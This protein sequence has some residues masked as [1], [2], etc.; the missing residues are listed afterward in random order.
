MTE[1]A[2]SLIRN[3]SGKPYVFSL[4]WVPPIIT[5]LFLVITSALTLSV[6][7]S[8]LLFVTLALSCAISSIF[9]YVYLR[10]CNFGFSTAVTFSLI[11][12]LGLF[13]FWGSLILLFMALTAFTD[14]VK[15]VT[16]KEWGDQYKTLLYSFSAIFVL[17]L[18][19]FGLNYSQPFNAMEIVN[20]DLHIDTLYHMAI[21]SMIKN[22]QVVSH[23]LHGL[24]DLEYH[25]GSHLLISSLST[26]GNI[27]IFN[28]YNFIYVFLV[29]PF[30]GIS[31]LIV[32]EELFPS[33]NIDIYKQKLYVYILLFL[34]SGLFLPF[35][36]LNTFSL[37]A[38]YVQSESYGVAL[39]FLLAQVSILLW[40]NG[41]DKAAGRAY[42]FA[43]LTLSVFTLLATASKISVGV[44]SVGVIGAWAL[45]STEKPFTDKWYF[46]WIILA[47][48][49]AFFLIMFGKINP[50]MADASFAPLQY[51]EVY[52][53]VSLPMWLKL[54]LFIV[55][56]FIF[57]ILALLLCVFSF[58][59]KEKLPLPGWWLAALIGSSLLGLG[60]VLVLFVVGGSG[61]Y[62][63]NIS[64]FLAI[65]LLLC[66]FQFYPTA[67]GSIKP[68]YKKVVIIIVFLHGSPVLGYGAYKY[69]QG[70]TAEIENNDLA[71]YLAKLKEIR[72]SEDNDNSVVYIPRSEKFWASMYQEP[73]DYGACRAT[74]YIIPAIAERPA[75]YSWPTEAC[76]S[77]LCGPRFHSNGL[78]AKSSELY[79]RE[80]VI[81]E[82][83]RLGFNKVYLVTRND[84]QTLK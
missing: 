7:Y 52:V 23:G 60:V 75:L 77:F 81:A 50:S 58:K 51:I 25:F 22:Y 84:I 67:F 32:S 14:T 65:P 70:M 63:S 66:F 42:I 47:V 82:A 59:H 43:G 15:K 34:G 33:D 68:L 56:H 78:C 28:A 53:N 37:G 54:P 4:I 19:Y 62:F 11:I 46:R 79:T 44:V 26:L 39:I 21:A 64:M 3:T 71:G 9:S 29:V 35:G 73:M 74:T 5:F 83:N 8:W 1:Q 2:G 69:L 16:K 13:R 57:P 31:V 72:D 36:L 80:E 18:P 48:S 10:T 55:F 41:L 38:N 24:G 30:I 49:F 40:I 12:F 61:V 6:E 27:S 76:Y 45:F 17:F 20:G